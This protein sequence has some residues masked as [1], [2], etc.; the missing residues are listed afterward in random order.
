MPD[1]NE[2]PSGGAVE[3]FGFE[4]HLPRTPPILS[5]TFPAPA[6]RRATPEPQ[7]Q[8]EG[9]EVE[10]NMDGQLFR[11]RP[12]ELIAPSRPPSAATP[13]AGSGRLSPIVQ[14][15][16]PL[17]AGTTSASCSPLKTMAQEKR[18]PSVKPGTW[19]S[20]LAT[21][22][23]RSVL[24]PVP[25]DNCSSAILQPPR[26]ARRRFVHTSHGRPHT[27]ARCGGSGSLDAG[28]RGGTAP[29]GAGAAHG[30]MAMGAVA[31]PPTIP[32]PVPNTP[33][34]SRDSS[35]WPP[36][37]Y[38]STT[39]RLHPR[40]PYVNGSSLSEA[41]APP[42]T[43]RTSTP[44][45]RPIGND[46]IPPIPP[47]PHHRHC[48]GPLPSASNR[49]AVANTYL[50]SKQQRSRRPLQVPAASAIERTLTERVFGAHRVEKL[51]LRS[52]LI[53]A[54]TRSQIYDPCSKEWQTIPK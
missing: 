43:P 49:V 22:V 10:E 30:W 16:G 25:P 20:H 23:L 33:W 50:R 54:V 46:L 21:G 34:A 48:R 2:G 7:L 28:T 42:S 6:A 1:S 19:T 18:T 3:R 8:E 14:P 51:Q 13:T 5:R 26:S 38:P 11:P 40:W 35:V 29:C 47:L 15:L 27:A 9:L 12:A 44:R 45:N 4:L 41:S 52:T 39:R 32:T 37:V 53:N 36:H 24:R 17:L 31:W